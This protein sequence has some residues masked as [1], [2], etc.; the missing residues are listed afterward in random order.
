MTGPILMKR[1]Y[2]QKKM[3]IAYIALRNLRIVTLIYFKEDI[4]VVIVCDFK[5]CDSHSY[6]RSLR[7][8]ITDRCCPF[9]D[10]TIYVER[11]RH[12]LAL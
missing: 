4:L 5:C 10:H 2:K 3:G 6:T 12:N 11:R 8:T 9:S 7:G 1:V